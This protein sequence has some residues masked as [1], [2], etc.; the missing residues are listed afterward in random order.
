VL[1]YR[2][3]VDRYRGSEQIIDEGGDHGFRD[4]DRYLDRALA[5]CGIAT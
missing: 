3:A 1:D 4:F 5:F 2:D